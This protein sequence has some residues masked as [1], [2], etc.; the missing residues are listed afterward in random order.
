MRVVITGG[1]GYIGSTL[2]PML[3]ADGHQVHVVDSLVFGGQAL[4]PLFIH[5]GFSL[6][7]VD[8]RD[9]VALKTELAGAD[10]VVHL[11]AMVGYPLCK[12]LPIEARQVNVDG[13]QNVADL[14]PPEALVIYSSTGSNYGEVEGICTEDTPLN[15]LSLYGETKTTGEAIC[16]S[17]GNSV[18][19][20]FATAYGIAP[21]MRL[22]L[23]IN[24]FT[25]QAVHRRYLVVYEKHFRRTFIHVRDIARAFCHVLKYRDRIEHDVYNVGHDSLNYTKEDI[26]RLLEE[27]V[28]F[29]VYFA[30]FGRDED[31]RDYEVDY[32]R[33]RSTG[34]E[35][36]IGIEQGLSELVRG[37]PLLPIANPYSNV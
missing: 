27:R 33:I 26:V 31:Q 12:K 23:M 16:R 24:D 19:L 3:L 7:Q 20:R 10:V 21:R 11:A 4:L 15:P 17:R 34:F 35:T 6:A 37:L 9:R 36:T 13:T 2:I 25:W 32:S 14:A 28:K 1:A 8:I 29:M 30:E 18:S 22:D 5:E